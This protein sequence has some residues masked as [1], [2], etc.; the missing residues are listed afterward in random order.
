MVAVSEVDLATNRFRLVTDQ[1]QV[2]EPSPTALAAA[3]G[4]CPAADDVLKDVRADG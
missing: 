1:G 4:G 2:Q 3:A